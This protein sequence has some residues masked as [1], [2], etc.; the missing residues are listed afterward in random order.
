MLFMDNGASFTI[1]E[2]GLG[3]RPREQL[4]RLMG[5][6]RFS[7]GLI[8]KLRTLTPVDIQQAMGEDPLGAVL[9][10]PQIEAVLLR[11]DRVIEQVDQAVAKLGEQAAYAFP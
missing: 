6:S 8:A 5:V 10:A 2:G 1:G 9:S 11:R 7:R 3:A 4:A